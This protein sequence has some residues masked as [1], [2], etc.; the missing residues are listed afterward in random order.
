MRS[1]HHRHSLTLVMT[2]IARGWYDCHCKGLD[3]CYDCHC[4]GALNQ[5]VRTRTAQ[6]LYRKTRIYRNPRLLT[7]H[8]SMPGL[9]R[10][11]LREKYMDAAL[12]LIAITKPTHVHTTIQAYTWPSA[13]TCLTEQLLHKH[14]REGT[15]GAA[16]LHEDARRCLPLAVLLVPAVRAFAGVSPCRV[17]APGRVCEALQ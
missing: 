14:P 8:N 6:Y 10:I 3:P 16:C 11:P 17:Q 15:S 13:T 2:A 12:V 7:V 5:P 9:K 1:D 4:K